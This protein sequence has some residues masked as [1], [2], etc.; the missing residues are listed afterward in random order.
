MNKQEAREFLGVSERTL[1][2]L[3]AG[4]KIGF[5]T[6]QG[7]TG[8]VAKFDRGEL[9][10]FKAERDKPVHRPAV[11]RMADDE[12]LQ[13]GANAGGAELQTLATLPNAGQIEALG[14]LLARLSPQPVQHEKPMVNV[15]D[16]LLL[17][18]AE[19]QQLTGLSR[20]VL[21]DA[22]DAKKLKAQQIGRAWRIKRTDLDAYVGK[23]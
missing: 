13:R 16:K 18:L 6:E 5:A 1:Q 8:K 14:N 4:G 12:G 22:I 21:R 15:A 19:S 17:T 2:N 10:R 11:Q 20:Q 3:M 23:L 7:K 9:E